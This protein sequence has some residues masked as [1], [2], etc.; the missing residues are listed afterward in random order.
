[1]AQL[2]DEFEGVLPLSLVASRSMRRCRLRAAPEADAVEQVAPEDLSALAE[3]V[4]RSG[5]V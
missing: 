3:A 5:S 2:S 4:T 1:V